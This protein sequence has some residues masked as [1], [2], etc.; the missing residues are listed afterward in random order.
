M[1]R[2]RLL[3][4][5]ALIVAISAAATDAPS[6]DILSR[7]RAQLGNFIKL[8]SDLKCTEQV[9]QSKLNKKGKVQES[10]KSTFDYLVIAQEAGP[11]L[12]LQES[13]L[14]QDSPGKKPNASMLVTNGFATLL[15]VFHPAYESSFSFSAPVMETVDGRKLA[16]IDFRHL[17]NKPST[18]E[19]VLRG[20]EYPLD[21]AGTAWVD[22][23]SGSIVK[24]E[25]GLE[26]AMEDIGLRVLHT[27]VEYG[28]VPLKGVDASI[29]LPQMAKVEVET[30]RQHWEN[31]HR[32]SGYQRFSVDVEEKIKSQ[33]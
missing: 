8:F 25:A 14:A 7:T 18:M 6:P 15:L 1:S 33:P 10:E 23:E 16:R 9:T 28:P 19:L 29:R 4:A 31:V 32:F 27:E 5:P 2:A 20:R 30:L 3:L 13:R 24:M 11:D 26:Q 21:L 22:P 12:T 17:H